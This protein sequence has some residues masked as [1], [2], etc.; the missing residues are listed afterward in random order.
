MWVAS[1]AAVTAVFCQSLVGWV[2]IRKNRLYSFA[3]GGW[4]RS[5]SGL[6]KKTRLAAT[7]PGKA[8]ICDVARVAG[9]GSMTVSRVLNHHPYVSEATA[10]RVR[11]AIAKL[12]YSPNDMARALRGSKVK[13]IGLIVPFLSDP[14]YANIAQSI[15]QVASSHGY[16]VL[17]ATS[18][19]DPQK[20]LSEVQIMM[21]RSIDGLIVAPA[22]RGRSRLAAYPFGEMP[23]VTLDR[24]LKGTRFPSVAVENRA[25]SVLAVRHLIEAHRHQNIAFVNLRGGVYTLGNRYEGYKKAMSDAGLTPG[26]QLVCPT[27]EAMFC[28]LQKLFCAARRPTA[29]FAAHGP[30]VSKLM[31]VLARLGISVPHDVAILA[32]DDWDL[33]DLIEPPL[34]VVRQPVTELGRISAEMLFSLLQADKRTKLSATTTILPVELVLRQSCG[35]SPQVSV[36]SA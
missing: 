28:L 21:R 1:A 11:R 14:F 6:P 3:P 8:T 5:L 22:A 16:S 23:L 4:R 13:T 26:P 12:D 30:A 25:G 2:T 34:T 35:C 29:I 9:V 31:H 24:L 10:A 27:Q 36:V 20:E 18:D 15:N 33:F 7:R 32:F 19:E 17:I